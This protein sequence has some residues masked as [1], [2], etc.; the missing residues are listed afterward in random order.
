MDPVTLFLKPSFAIGV[1]PSTGAL[2]VE[3]RVKGAP[4]PPPPPR[5]R[6]V[7]GGVA[8]R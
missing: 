5:L 3:V 2:E 6:L 1:Q 8:R 4:P 7:K